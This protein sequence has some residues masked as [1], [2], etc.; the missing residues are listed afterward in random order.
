MI[1][2]MEKYNI[3]VVNWVQFKGDLDFFFGSGNIDWEGAG[4]SIPLIREA[5]KAGFQWTDENNELISLFPITDM[6]KFNSY[7]AEFLVSYPAMCS[8]VAED[9]AVAARDA[10]KIIADAEAEAAA[11]TPSQEDIYKAQ[12]LLLLTEISN[13][14]GAGDN[15]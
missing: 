5:V 11:N 9:D 7:F 8:L 12:Q 15:G 3:E 6:I 10:H 4:F 14:L 13:K 1:A 2:A